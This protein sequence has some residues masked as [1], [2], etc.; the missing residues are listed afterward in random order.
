MIVEINRCR[1]CGSDLIELLNLGVHSL[2]C[3]F[4]FNHEEDPISAPLI[5]VKCN[6]LNNQNNCGLV[7][8]KHNVSSDELYLHNYGYRSGL[9]KTMTTHLGDL[10][11]EILE[12][13]ELENNDIILDIGSNDCTLLKNYPVN[14]QRIGIDPTGEQFRSFYPDDIKL[15]PDFFTYANYSKVFEKKAKII[16]SISMF[17]DLPDPIGF[18]SDI[19]RILDDKGVWVCEQSYIVTML[20]RFSFDTICHEH[21][22]YYAFKQLEFMAQR[23][24][25]KIIDV[26][27]NEC[28]GGS[29]RITFA[30]ANS[31]YQPNMD[32]IN[33][34]KNIELSMKL[35][36]L[37]PYNAFIS[38]IERVKENLV[39]FLRD[40]KK[41]GKS[42][43]L[44]GASTKGN[45]L[46]Q[47]FNIDN[48]LVTAAAER[49]TEKFGRRTPRTNIPI[50]S[51]AE[52]RQAK[53]DYLLVLP[54]H[55]R[56]E[57]IDREQEYLDKGGQLIFPLPKME[58]YTNKKKAL[59]TGINGQ[60]GRYLGEQLL[61]QNYIVYGL[62]HRNTDNLNPR[63]HY[64]Q[65]DLSN[66]SNIIKT[67]EPEEIYNLAGETNSFN[68]I[69][70]P[71]ETFN[72]C[73]TAVCDICETIY[74]SGKDIKFVQVNSIELYKGLIKGVTEINEETLSFYPDTP[75]GYA[76]LASFW[77]VRYYREK[78]GCK[79]SSAI[80]S[81]SESRYRKPQ[82]ITTKIGNY[83]KQLKIDPDNKELLYLGNLDI[84]KDWIHSSDTAKAL[85]MMAKQDKGSDYMVC[86]GVNYTVRELVEKFFMTIGIELV[87]D[88]NN[89]GYDKKNKRH[90]VCINPEFMRKNEGTDNV[91]VINNNKLKF[92]GWLP[93]YS[94]DQ[95]VADLV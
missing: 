42:I 10:A 49:N 56:D 1:I 22:E 95:I 94:L 24:G 17:Y 60:V 18:M 83:I 89:N 87:W 16:T 28:N 55:F 12:K 62:L 61:E 73:A 58:I 48:T 71:L 39:P 43:Y 14:V 38:N 47:Y 31:A 65:G 63:I 86:S 3:R 51:E 85:C 19:K 25:L 69:K 8:L 45:T 35:N 26:T 34:L 59:V 57:F 68:A 44:Y 41:F 54:W 20:E 5:L 53:P 32:N 6:D 2:S 33:K 76:K 30:N 36:S 13:V 72:M 29:F 11:K 37:E 15:V 64:N 80:L 46:L 91:L 27:L 74:K 84:K 90:Y 50:I 7:Q 70:N 52:M 4:P 79:F 88:S 66:I 23:V 82:F 67:V 78:Y 75:Y 9:N 21:L 77:A 40:I 81:N 92:I 93:E